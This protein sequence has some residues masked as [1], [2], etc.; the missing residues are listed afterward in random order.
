[1][2]HCVS[3]KVTTQLAIVLTVAI[4]AFAALADWFGYTWRCEYPSQKE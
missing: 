3:A 1:M 2:N 4:L